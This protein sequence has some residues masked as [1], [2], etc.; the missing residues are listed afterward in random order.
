M[1]K[2]LSNFS[3]RHH[4]ATSNNHPLK[5]SI[6]T[7]ENS[8][9]PSSEIPFWNW[10]LFARQ[11]IFRLD[12][13]NNDPPPLL[14]KLR[15]PG[16]RG[17][18]S[19]ANEIENNL[20]SRETIICPNEPHPPITLDHRSLILRILTSNLIVEIFLLETLLLCP[21][22]FRHSVAE[23]EAKGE[24]RKAGWKWRGGGGKKRR[25]LVDSME[26]FGTEATSA[27]P[28]TKG[29]LTPSL[30][31][32]SLSFFLSFFFEKLFTRGSPWAFFIRARIV[33]SS[34]VARSIRVHV[35]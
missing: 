7:I 5:F 2:F 14:K 35:V 23:E 1:S 25:T 30:R 27:R 19:A 20:S 3:R 8:S 29:S 15:S 21:S 16:Y 33:F 34:T 12:L 32:L 4:D 10:L 28:R 9:K 18:I 6:K 22:R 17:L 11:I 31:F 24:E 26:W 13:E